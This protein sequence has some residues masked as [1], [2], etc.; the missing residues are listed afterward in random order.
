MYVPLHV[1]SDGS[2]L[3]GSCR[4]KDYVKKCKDMGSTH[5][6]IS[7]HGNMINAMAFQE[8]CDKQGMKPVFGCEFYMGEPGSKD[9]YHL[10]LIAKNNTGLKNLYRLNAYAYTQNFYGKPR[11]DKEH[12]IRYKE[13]LI[14]CSACLG[15][16]LADA[17]RTEKAYAV[18]S[19]IP[20]FSIWFGDD[21]YLELQSNS[22]QQQ[23]EYNEYLYKYTRKFAQKCIVTTD[24][25]YV[26]KEDAEVHDTLLCMQT[27]KKKNDE[28][29]FRFSVN[30]FYVQTE[31]EIKTMLDYLP[32]EFLADCLENT[33]E[34]ADKCTARIDTS[35]SYM[36][37][38][39]DNAD[40][41]LALKCNEGYARRFG[42][43]RQ[44]VIDRI[45]YELKVIKEKSYSDYFLIVQD[46][47]QHAKN[48]GIDV[49]P[50]RG[51]GAGSE[52][53][54][55]LGITDV[56]PIQHGLLFERFLN[57]E[58]MSAPDFD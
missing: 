23:K 9:K 20:S 48:E 12:L 10:L 29:R 18:L 44:D 39:C 49:G 41:Q 40:Y 4:L 37:V 31:D 47:V 33:V 34:I 52:V 38:F 58:R 2:V 6:G 26:D 24:A 46:Y 51:S 55:V 15:S 32:E 22:L 30:E 42:T 8:E 11:I 45:K 57:P 56:E 43:K 19:L 17:Y 25:H 5:C 35:Q 3:D 50:G 53:A 13:G 28:K 54:Y 36:P 16:E 1:H 7:D 14:C 21:Y 27:N